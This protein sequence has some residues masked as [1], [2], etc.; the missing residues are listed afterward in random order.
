MIRYR[1]PVVSNS[2]WFVR[3]QGVTEGVGVVDTAALLVLRESIK[4]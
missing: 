2:G 1:L 3:F 4:S